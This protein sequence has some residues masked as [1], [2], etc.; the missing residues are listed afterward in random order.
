[1]TAPETMLSDGSPQRFILLGASNLTLSFPLILE[2]LRRRVEGPL[3]VYAALGHGRSF[4][5]WS[6]VFCRSLPG[7][8]SSGMWEHV[9]R[10]V[11]DYGGDR[12]PARAL[13]TDVGNDLI[14]DVPVPQIVEWLEA[15][16]RR[17]DALNTE[18]VVTLLPLGSMEKLQAWRYYFARTVMFPTRRCSWPEM[19]RRVQELNDRLLELCDRYRARTFAPP[20]EWYGFDPIH[21]VR[22]RRAQAWTEILSH[23][24]GFSTGERFDRPRVSTMARFLAS[25]PAE[26]RWFG[27]AQTREQPALALDGMTVSLF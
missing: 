1:M 25:C 3:K 10:D 27:V 13:I 26:R 20:G 6:S 15:S 22:S 18:T 14:Y 7:I 21:I 11:K 23:W 2:N 4:G 12:G 16:F 8:A 19:Q 17:L 9:E 24:S 5:N